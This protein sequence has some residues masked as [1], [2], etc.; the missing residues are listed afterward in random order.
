MPRWFSKSRDPVTGEEFWQTNG[1]Y[2]RI[3]EE[4]EKGERWEG[5]GWRIF[6]RMMM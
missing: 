5:A 1:R 2:W 4:A 6:L 3:R